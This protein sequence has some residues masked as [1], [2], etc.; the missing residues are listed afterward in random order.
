MEIRKIKMCSKDGYLIDDKD[1]C[2]V[3]NSNSLRN[4][5][6]LLNIHSVYIIAFTRTAYRKIDR[7]RWYNY[8]P[9]TLKPGVN[10]YELYNKVTDNP[11]FLSIRNAFFCDECGEVNVDVNNNNICESCGSIWLSPLIYIL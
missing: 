5:S 1:K 4:L 7:Q 11:N 9:T 8:N 3:C 2:P 10:M 6:D